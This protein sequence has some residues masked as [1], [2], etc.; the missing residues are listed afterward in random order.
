[1][2]DAQNALKNNEQDLILQHLL[3]RIERDKRE[4]EQDKAERA[5]AAQRGHEQS[6]MALKG[7]AAVGAA[8][9]VGSGLQ[10]FG[11]GRE[12]TPAHAERHS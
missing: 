9:A 11:R 6:L 2:R 3:A 8:S 4:E 7:A 12:Q 1:V 5:A 10:H